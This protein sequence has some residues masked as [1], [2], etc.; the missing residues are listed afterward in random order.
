MKTFP[1]VAI[2]AAIVIVL[3]TVELA[4]LMGW[5]SFDNIVANFFIFV[6]SLVTIF[7][8]A[9]IGAIFVGM[10]I[11]HRVLSTQSFT[12]FEEEMLKMRR[13]IT[14]VKM[15]LEEKLGPGTKDIIAEKAREDTKPVGEDL[16]VQ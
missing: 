8:L 12:P 7:I 15:L 11:T 6:F 10:F 4:Q 9:V 1:K 16:D 14:E 2:W 5:I 3:V 13:D